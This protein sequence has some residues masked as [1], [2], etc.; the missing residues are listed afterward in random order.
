MKTF[1]T[2]GKTTKSFSSYTG[3][4]S[5]SIP[6]TEIKSIWTTHAKCKSISMLTTKTRDFRPAFK[7]QVNFDH[8]H[9]NQNQFTP[10]LKSIQIRSP[11]LKLSQLGS[12]TQKN[13][14][15]CP[16]WKQVIFGQYT[17]NRSISTTHVIPT[18]KSI[19][20]RSP[21]LRWSLFRPPSQKPTHLHVRTKNE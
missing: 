2:T 18:L 17:S 13:Q 20:V 16:S 3:I 10:T 4:K 15:S 12:P 9:K 1:L 8:P 6:H 7:N 21:T 11:T 5:S 14:W 19:Q